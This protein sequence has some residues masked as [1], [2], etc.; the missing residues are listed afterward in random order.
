MN[1]KQYLR[2]KK[3]SVAELSRRTGIPYTTLSELVNG[4]VDV[5][6][7][8]VGNAV[9]IA[10]KCNLPFQQFYEMCKEQTD[11]GGNSD[12]RIVTRN[13]KYYVQ[14]EIDGK[15]STSYLFKANALNQRFVKDVAQ[16]EYEAAKEQYRE[17]KEIEEVERWAEDIT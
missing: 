7:I 2:N 12:Y 6:R 8:Y 16:W 4:K 3:V 13:K 9:N 10:E 5:D 17:K 1:F 14:Y 15:T 11:I